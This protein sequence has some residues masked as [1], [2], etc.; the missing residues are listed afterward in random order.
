M[1]KL[2][3]KTATSRKTSKLSATGDV[4]DWTAQAVC[5]ADVAKDV[6]VL[7]RFLHIAGEHPEVRRITGTEVLMFEGRKTGKPLFV[8]GQRSHFQTVPN[9][10]G[11]PADQFGKL[12]NRSL[13]GMTVLEVNG[14]LFIWGSEAVLERRVSDVKKSLD[15]YDEKEVATAAAQA[16]ASKPKAAPVAT[17]APASRAQPVRSS[18]YT[19]PSHSSASTY[20]DD[21]IGDFMFMS[22][23]P[24]VA[25]L[26]RPNSFLAWYLWAE[27]NNHNYRNSWDYQTSNGVPGFSDAYSQR[28]TPCY[29]GYQVELLDRNGLGVGS[30]VVRDNG[31][32]YET[33]DGQ[34]FMIQGSSQPCVVYQNDRQSFSWDGVSDPIIGS[35]VPDVSAPIDQGGYN[36]FEFQVPDAP[37]QESRG[38]GFEFS[39]P[40]VPAPEPQS[41]GSFEFSVPSSNL[42]SSTAY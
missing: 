14:A 22:M 12:W 33:P 23:F 8:Y 27:H 34:Q 21:D 19:Q 24:E 42:D 7:R 16:P 31:R 25:P 20:R 4:L 17:K 9:S 41:A 40:D 5:H 32:C 3:L 35:P 18:G 2:Q 13:P 37:V 39:V 1:L 36:S 30:F 26:Y 15:C 11:V 28:I 6:Y 10:I 38:G 29:E